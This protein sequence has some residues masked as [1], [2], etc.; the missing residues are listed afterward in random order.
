MLV[1]LALI[2]CRRHRAHARADRRR[3]R[4][5]FSAVSCS[6]GF[7]VLKPNEFGRAHTVRPL[8]RHGAARRL[9][10]GQPV[11]REAKALAPRAQLHDADAQ[12]ERQG[13]QPDRRRR[14]RRLAHQ[15][16]SPSRLRRRRLR[17]L[18]QDAV[19]D[20]AARRRLDASLRRKKRR[21]RLAPRQ[22]GCDIRPAEGIAPA[23]GQRG[24]HRNARDAHHAPCL[25]AGNRLDHAPPPA[26][27]SVDPSPR[28]DGRWRDR[29]GQDG[30]RPLPDP[31]A[32]PT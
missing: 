27:R 20:G 18:H 11:L 25:R 23:L 21:T 13:R 14:R 29:H 16:H 5:S 7:L 1:V 32:S 26:S 15:R 28:K 6:V 4:S 2:V 17:N 10:L 3:P 9:P 8:R 31:K 19:R 22:H 12:S 30:A 24:R